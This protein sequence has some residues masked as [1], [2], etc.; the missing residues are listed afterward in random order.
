MFLINLNSNSS[1][2]KSWQFPHGV[3]GEILSHEFNN[4]PYIVPDDSILYV[5]AVSISNDSY[6]L[7]S[8]KD[9]PDWLTGS[10]PLGKPNN[11]PYIFGPSDTIIHSG[12]PVG[13]KPALHGILFKKTNDINPKSLYRINFNFNSIHCPR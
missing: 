9:S 3:G 11:N 12:S 1:S 4:S 5:T 8:P 2:N 6:L 10:Y 13:T 7:V